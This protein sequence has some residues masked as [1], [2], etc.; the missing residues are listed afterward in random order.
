MS[1]TRSKRRIPRLALRIYLVGL[2]QF[3][4][5]ALGLFIVQS[6]G[7]PPRRPHDD[8]LRFVA[9]HVE[10]RLAEPDDLDAELL[11]ASAD[12]RSTFVVVDPSGTVRASEPPDATPCKPGVIEDADSEDFHGP[13]PHPRHRGQHP[14]WFASSSD[15]ADPP[16]LFPP[17]PPGPHG[18]GGHLGPRPVRGGKSDMGAFCLVTPLTFPDGGEGRLYQ[19]VTMNRPPSPGPFIIVAVLVVV[20]ISS[21]LLARSLLGPLQRMQTT[22]RAIGGGDLSARVKLMRGDELGEVARAFDDMAEKVVEL[23]HAEKELLA[24]VSHELRT[25][26]ARIRVALDIAAEGDAEAAQASLADITGD[27]DELERLISDTLTAAR[28]DLAGAAAPTSGIPP[29]RKERLSI[30]S[31]ADAASQR[32]RM[33][34]PE[35]ALTVE[36]APDLPAVVGDPVLLRRAVDNLLDNAAKYTERA[37]AGVDLRAAMADGF[38]EI[39][40]VD[41]GI[42]IAESDLPHVFR[43][44]FRADK[45][46]TRAT[47][48]LGLGLALTKRIVVAHGGSIAIESSL[49][50]GTTVRI[51]MPPASE[52]GDPPEDA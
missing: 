29:L 35:R 24:N 31:I 52:E 10:A 17:G 45:S 13:P 21:W 27:L 40:V 42:G 44:F 39:Q 48:G 1:A 34:H 25:P 41:A 4:A 22:A 16:P 43:P 8:Q 11:A 38:I 50:V 36:I 33:R 46:R 19:L 51:T 2:A 18:E 37:D 9:R 5:V 6:T 28:L 15:S 20:G 7:S 12:M 32:F 49:G 23:F 30:G 14:A 26:L 3:A 47:G